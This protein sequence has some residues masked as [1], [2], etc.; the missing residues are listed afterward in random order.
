[1]TQMNGES[2]VATGLPFNDPD[3]VNHEDYDI[4]CALGVDLRKYS[5]EIPLSERSRIQI[6]D[7]G[8]DLDGNSCD[9]NCVS[10]DAPCSLEE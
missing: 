5:P 7:E 6:V 2:P 1:M 4:F 10:C 9:Y 8:D 3:F